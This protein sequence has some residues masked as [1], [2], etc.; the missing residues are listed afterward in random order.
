MGYIVFIFLCWVVYPRQ[1]VTSKEKD[2]IPLER[3]EGT[4]DEGETGGV[5]QNQTVS[6]ECSF[7]N[8][9]IDQPRVD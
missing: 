9:E 3:V 2:G 1:P 4:A 6:S 7:M 8:T 5:E